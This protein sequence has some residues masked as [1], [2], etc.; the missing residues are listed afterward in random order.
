MGEQVMKSFATYGED[1]IFEGI[2]S[3]LEW[4]TG[5][6]IGM[7]TFIEIGGFH[8]IIDSNT[9][10]LYKERGWAGSVFE[11]NTVHNYYFETDRPRDKFH[12]LAVSKM[13]GEA[14]FLIFSDGD[15]SNT[16]NANFA[17]EKEKAQ[18]TSIA[19]SQKVEVVTLNQVFELHREVFGNANP[20]LL[21]IDAEGE[22]LAIITGCNFNDYRP[23]FIM[24]EDRP[25][26]S[27]FPNLGMIRPALAERNYH[28]I[29]SSILT[30]IYI[31]YL[32]KESEDYDKMGRFGN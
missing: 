12:N 23:K 17:E 13:S 19:R 9:Y 27:Y 8:P 5:Q 1:A 14:E 10:H 20:Y 11:P 26:L 22:D 32:S 21:S 30:T 24:I 2:L 4:V 7:Q 3:R 31:D 15:N 6:R 25:G 28:P 16:I 29:A 18:R